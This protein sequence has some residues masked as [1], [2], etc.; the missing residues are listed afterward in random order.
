MLKHVSH[1]DTPQDDSQRPHRKKRRL[2]KVSM[3]PTLVTLGSVCFGFAAMYC[4][5][6]EM[7]DLGARRSREEVKT[8]KI[9]FFED[10]AGTFLSIAAWLILAGMICDAIDGGLAYAF[11]VTDGRWADGWLRAEIRILY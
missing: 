2:K 1:D 8:F 9:Q 5:A 4:C 7:E 6:R 3:L 10:R 11:P